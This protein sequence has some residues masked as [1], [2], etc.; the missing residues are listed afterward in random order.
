MERLCKA[1]RPDGGRCRRRSGAV[2][3]CFI[4]DP[5]RAQAREIVYAKAAAQMHAFNR[6]RRRGVES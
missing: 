2:E 1:T 6:K 4:H 3:F 5:A